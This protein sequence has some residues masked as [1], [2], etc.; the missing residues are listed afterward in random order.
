ME[1]IRFSKSFEDFVSQTKDESKVSKYLYYYMR[2]SHPVVVRNF[3]SEKMNYLTFRKNG[4]ISYLPHGR[5]LKLTDNGEWSRE[6][7]QDGKPA[8]TITNIM[9]SAAL[10]SL[11]NRDLEIFSNLYK[12]RATDMFTIRE[13]RGEDIATVY[14]LDIPFS[15]CMNGDRHTR[16]LEMYTKNP[17]SVGLLYIQTGLVCQARALIW[18]DRDGNKIIDRVY[19]SE[20]FQTMFRDYAKEIGAYKKKYDGAGESPFYEPNGETL[21]YKPFYIEL[22]E[23]VDDCYPYV[24]TFCYLNDDCEF[25]LCN[26]EENEPTK[27]LQCTGGGYEDMRGVEVY[28]RGGSR[29]PE[30]DCRWSEYH[31]AW[32]HEDDAVWI[33]DTGDYYY[34]EDGSTEDA[35]QTGRRRYVLVYDCEEVEVF[36]ADDH[37][38]LVEIGDVCTFTCYKLPDGSLIP[39]DDAE[40]VTVFIIDEEIKGRD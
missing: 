6:G 13:V 20:E 21:T 38:G 19:G 25:T 7:R 37:D 18:T 35:I 8:K 10:R 3:T 9:R 33:E 17:E 11:T 22:K 14:T 26:T 28:G 16:K 29:Y 32:V 2:E 34:A 15:S 31:D 27:K 5:E 12:G 23:S 40:V 1:K 39:K 30:R 36:N 24:D 4:T